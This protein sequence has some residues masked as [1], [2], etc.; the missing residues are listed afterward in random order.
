L[1][2][3]GNIIKHLF[4]IGAGFVGFLTVISSVYGAYRVSRITGMNWLD[5]LTA[6]DAAA[7]FASGIV[8]IICSSLY[9]HFILENDKA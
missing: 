5:A 4:W 6:A 7:H 3:I 8:I 2:K 1:K 9:N